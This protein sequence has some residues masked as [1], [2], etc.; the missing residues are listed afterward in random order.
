M[1]LAVSVQKQLN[2][3]LD[4]ESIQTAV[5]PLEKRIVI[6]IHQESSRVVSAAQDQ[7]L[8]CERHVVDDGRAVCGTSNTR[9]GKSFEIA[10]EESFHTDMDVDPSS[11]CVP[12]S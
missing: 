10:G 9:N 8:V 5:E 7:A 6:D 2:S 1:S 3:L 11:I 4:K 12:S